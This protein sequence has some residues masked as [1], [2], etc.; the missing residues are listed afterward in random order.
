[1]TLNVRS[2]LDPAGLL[3]TVRQVVQALRPN[4]PLT[5]V[6]TAEQLL[7]TL[8]WAPRMGT[9]LLT[10]FGLLALVL[11]AVGIYGVMSYSVNQ[12]TVEFGLRMALGARPADIQNL[13]LKQG[14]FL[15][16]AGVG[17]GLLTALLVS[18][19]M[20]AL[21]VGTSPSD[22][23]TFAT[24]SF[25]LAIVAVIAGYVPARRA[26]KVDPMIALRYE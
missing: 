14:M 21:L 4:M 24:I 6:Q 20:A 3:P 26:T 13:V 23:A 12:R 15:C 9:A 18:R 25:I 8:L 11:A 22:P 16:A 19:F 10:I 17:M 1:M 5:N 2:A 7:A